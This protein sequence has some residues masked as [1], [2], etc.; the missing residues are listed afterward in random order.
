MLVLTVRFHPQVSRRRRFSDFQLK[1]FWAWDDFSSYIYCFL[2]LNMCLIA[3]CTTWL[4]KHWF[5]E[6]LGVLALGVEAMLAV[7]QAYR[8]HK[9]QSV[10]G[11][12]CVV[13]YGRP[14]L[15]EARDSL[16]TKALWIH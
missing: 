13:Q 14:P 11:L 6:M 8:N 16:C 3:A 1:D 2:T 15:H 4:H 10:D 9:K 7:P 5:G 12:R